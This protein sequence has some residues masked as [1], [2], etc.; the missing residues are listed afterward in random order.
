MKKFFVMAVA[1]IFALSAQAQSNENE[2]Y[3]RPYLSFAQTSFSGD[4]AQGKP[5]FSGFQIGVARGL[6]LSKTTPLFLELGLNVAYQDLK[7]T[8]TTYNEETGAP[9]VQ[10]EEKT[11][12]W[13]LFVPVNVTYKYKIGDS[14][15]TLAPYAGLHFRFNIGGNSDLTITKFTD[16]GNTT[17]K[18]ERNLFSPTD[19]GGSEYTP[20]HIQIG[21]QAG[22]A[23]EWK[24]LHLGVGY[25]FDFS[26][27]MTDVKSSGL[28]IAVG[29]TF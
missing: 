25:D 1:C 2:G 20:N 9:D 3:L 15:F 24:R 17:E 27:F 22:V 19:M 23:V 28:R 4:A 16:D 13:S 5:S 29:V 21:A 7:E 14:G 18:I 10:T 12:L 8:T 26:E 11:N 6:S